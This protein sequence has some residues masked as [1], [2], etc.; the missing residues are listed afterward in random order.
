MV[1]DDTH[2]TRGLIYNNE[3]IIIAR[4]SNLMHLITRVQDEAHRFAITYHRSMRDKNMLHS[5]LD[6]ITNVGDKRRKSLLINFGSIENIKSAKLEDIEKVTSIDKKTAKSI[7][8]FFH[9][10]KDN[11]LGGEYK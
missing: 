4:H 1:K 7:Y 2:S 5:I 10:A 6:D 11:N 3:E 9:I 8:D